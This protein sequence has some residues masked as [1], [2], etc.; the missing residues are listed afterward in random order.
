MR[1]AGMLKTWNFFYRRSRNSHQILLDD[2][3]AAIFQFGDEAHVRL[4]RHHDEDVWPG[5]V[6]V[7]D[8]RIGKDELRAAGAAS[9]FRT[10]VLS[11]G[12]KRALKNRGCL[13][14]NYGRENHALAAE[15]CDT[16]FG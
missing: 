4:L 15:A 12:G 9:G 5:D 16:N 13:A 10:E 11:H 6:R 3:D 8:W 2:Q 7:Q 14:E 1:V